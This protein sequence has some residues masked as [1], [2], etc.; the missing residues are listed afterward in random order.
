MRPCRII[1]YRRRGRRI[2]YRSR[3]MIHHYPSRS[4]VISVIPVPVITAVVAT[5][6]LP[7]LFVMPAA[8]VPIIVVPLC[9]GG[10]YKATQQQ[11]Q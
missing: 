11:H 1:Y 6:T 4:A 7:V 3:M 2:I 8:S 10:Q 5:V 9:L